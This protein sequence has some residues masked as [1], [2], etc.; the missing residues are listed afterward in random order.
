MRSFLK[1]AAATVTRLVFAIDRMEGARENVEAAGLEFNA[2]LT[3]R[4]LGIK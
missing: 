2:I 3:A 1:E 4:D